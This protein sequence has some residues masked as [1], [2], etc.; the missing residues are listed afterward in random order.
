MEPAK[1]LTYRDLVRNLIYESAVLKKLY[2]GNKRHEPFLQELIK[3]DSLGEDPLP[4]QKDL[5]DKLSM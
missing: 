3:Y 1:K 2:K 5:L 4:L